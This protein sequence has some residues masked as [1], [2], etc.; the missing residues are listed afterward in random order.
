MGTAV[1][2]LKGGRQVFVALQQKKASKKL[3]IQQIARL[4]E[5]LENERESIKKEIS[6]LK[7]EM[8][9]EIQTPFSTHMEHGS[10]HQRK[11]E[12]AQEL[13]RANKKLIATEDALERIKRGTY[14]ICGRKGCGKP[15]GIRRME[16]SIT[17]ERCCACM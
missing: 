15:I 3:S 2:A 17:A 8:Q 14:G 1:H 9:S 7:E 6:L 10:E 12:A 13:E 11:H 16:A 5:R 4:K